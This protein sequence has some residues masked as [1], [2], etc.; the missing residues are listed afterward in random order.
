MN[1]FQHSPATTD[2]HV[3]RSAR[4]RWMCG[5]ARSLRAIAAPWPS[6]GSETKVTRGR[7]A[8]AR[9]AGS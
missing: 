9:R 7:P 8:V 3:A 2:G 1:R 4:K 6:P 5:R